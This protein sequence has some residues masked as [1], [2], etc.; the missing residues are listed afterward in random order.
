[1]ARVK[2]ILKNTVVTIIALFIAI[3][4][5]S[6]Y[7]L[8]K[9][10]APIISGDVERGIEYKKDLKLDLYRPT[11]NVF[12]TSPVVFF[13]H[14]G[15][16]IGGT[17]ASINFDR[18]N[19]A[20]NTLREEGYTVISPNYTLAGEGRTVFPQCILDIYDAIEWTKD[21]ASVY[22]LDTTNLGILG[23]SA[24]AHIAMMI[25][26]P[27]ESLQPEKYKKT[28]FR[29]LIDVYGPNDLT[30]IYHGHAIE[31]IEASVKKVSKIFGS[32]F[33]IK[34]YVFG[35]DPNKDSIRANELLNRY[36]PVNIL[37]RNEIPVLIIHGKKDQIVPVEQSI[38][39]KQ[40]LD[41]L[42]VPNEIRLLNNVDHNFR[43]ATREQKDSM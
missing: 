8:L 43:G 41:S 26:F 27:E 40:K 33:N 25:A 16:W 24:G 7:F 36:S 13:I 5:A 32:E 17:K 3:A 4:V 34:E 39:L 12:N 23:E 30:G 2:A 1:M 14:G 38:K 9:N 20:V 21:N 18:F 6:A 10:D 19:G 11:K 22:G 31:K 37:S 15:A 29:Y 35:F 28:K 42:G